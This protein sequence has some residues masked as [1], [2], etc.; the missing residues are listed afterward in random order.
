MH[1]ALPPKDIIESDSET[2]SASCQ[3]KELLSGYYEF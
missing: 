2:E 3:A 1:P